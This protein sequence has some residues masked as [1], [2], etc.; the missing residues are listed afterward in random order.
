MFSFTSLKKFQA[1]AA[2]LGLD[3][4][5]DPPSHE[6]MHADDVHST[7]WAGNK[8]KQ[9]QSGDDVQDDM[10]LG[11]F[12]DGEG[13]L[14][15]NPDESYRYMNG[16]GEQFEIAV[17]DELPPTTYKEAITALAAHGIDMAKQAFE[18]D[19]EGVDELHLSEFINEMLYENRGELKEEIMAEVD[20]QLGG[21]GLAG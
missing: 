1:A 11:W 19:M 21:P 17:P 13:V 5:G 8:G 7:T 20:K 18:D 15:D 14:F 12:S 4:W 6:G 3:T 10:V 9:M 16:D 2:V